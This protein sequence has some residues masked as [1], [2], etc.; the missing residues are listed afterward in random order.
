MNRPVGVSGPAVVV[1]LFAATLV[2][3][4]TIVCG[5]AMITV[6][7]VLAVVV[8]VVVI[9]GVAPTLWG[10]RDVPVWRWVV[11]GAVVGVLLGWIALIGGA[12]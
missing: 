1:A 6:Q 10:W 5:A 11:Y 12:R 7:P 2:A 4:A 9:A 3:V 8:N